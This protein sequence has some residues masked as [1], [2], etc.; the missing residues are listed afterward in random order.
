MKSSII[1]W[2]TLFV[3][4]SVTNA[5][6]AS[7]YEINIK[8]NVLLTTSDAYGVSAGD[9][10]SISYFVDN[11]SDNLANQIWEESD[12]K[13]ASFNFNNGALVVSFNYPFSNGLSTYDMNFS[14]DSS[15]GLWRVGRFGDEA[16]GND[17]SI[18]NIGLSPTSWLP[19]SGFFNFTKTT[20]SSG[21]FS[22]FID[23]NPLANASSYS[24]SAVT[25]VPEPSSAILLLLG[26]GLI[27]LRQN[28][29]NINNS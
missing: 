4:G 21:N 19:L 26:L 15:G 6:F 1:S 11:G 5:A 24:I 22:I 25:P 27:G 13:S 20:V 10:V 8:T 29:N 14:T 9:N 17:F 12:I 7:T 28:R 23:N 18:S 3:I 16:V 2:A